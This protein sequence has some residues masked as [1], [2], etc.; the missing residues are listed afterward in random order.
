MIACSQVLRVLIDPVT[1]AARGVK[2]RR[3][4]RTFTVFATR[5][6]ILSAGALNTPQVSGTPDSETD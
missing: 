6:V 2:Y 4:G 3:G 5:E 1:L